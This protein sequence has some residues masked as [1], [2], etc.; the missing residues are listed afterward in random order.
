VCSARRKDIEGRI[1]ALKFWGKVSTVL[2]KDKFQLTRLGAI[3]LSTSFL[4]LCMLSTP[5]LA[6][7]L[8]RFEDY[9]VSVYLG[10]IHPPKWI[11]RVAS[12]EWRDDLGK[13]VEPPEINFAGKYFLAVHSCGTGCR[14]YT[15]TDLSSG[16]DLDVL[17]D[18][19]TVEPLPKTRDG[20]EYM[21][22]LFSRPNSRMLVAQYHVKLSQGSEECRERAFLFEDEKLKSITNTRR[23]CRRL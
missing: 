8:P 13:L 1:Q 16:R 3:R 14:Y 20:H 17:R 10:A 4:I 15:L 5:L 19:D 12:D 6:D 11:R 7:A 2:T 21:T 18:F 9:E 22:E 23:V